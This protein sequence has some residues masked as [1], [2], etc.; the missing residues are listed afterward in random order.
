[1]GSFKVVVIIS[2]I[3]TRL[4]FRPI[5]RIRASGVSQRGILHYG[6]LYI[7][8][9]YTEYRAS[10]CPQSFV[11][12]FRKPDLDFLCICVRERLNAELDEERVEV[13][14]LLELVLSSLS[15]L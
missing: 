1:M 2:V 8:Y 11:A 10:F 3:M 13:A 14:V 6:K 7:V 5:G 12:E 15:E 4:C 9:C